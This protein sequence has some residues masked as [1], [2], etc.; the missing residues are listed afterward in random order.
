M[1]S[2][3]KSRRHRKNRPSDSKHKH[4]RNGG[5]SGNNNNGNNI[6]NA[7]DLHHQDSLGN[8]VKLVLETRTEEDG[9]PPLPVDAMDVTSPGS[10]V[11]DPAFNA[12]NYWKTPFPDVS[13][14]VSME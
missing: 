12:F 6:N 10:D 14:D 11:D 13:L 4:G 8:P 5:S 2:S 1:P 9:G 7:D 3:G